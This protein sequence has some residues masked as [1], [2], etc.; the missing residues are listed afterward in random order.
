MGMG[1]LDKAVGDQVIDRA[2]NSEDY[3]D[4]RQ[5]FVEKRR[6]VFKGV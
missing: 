5:A 6:P 3:R 4:A 2:V 1:A